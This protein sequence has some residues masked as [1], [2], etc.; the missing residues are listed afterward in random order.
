MID[1]LKDIAF[2]IHIEPLRTVEHATKVE[3][4]IKVLSDIYQSYNN[5]LEIE[6]LK[7]ENFKKVFETNKKVL[8]TIK[9]ELSLLVVDL[10]FSSFEAAL[11]P[12]VIELQSPI[13]KNEVLEWKKETFIEYKDL[14]IGGDYEDSNYL[15]KVAKRY[16]EEERTKIFK[17]LFLSFGDGKDYKV[18][19]KDKN[20]KVIKTLIQPEKTK[21]FYVIPKMI[22]EKSNVSEYSTFQVFAKVKKQGDKV[23][24]NQRNLKE[25]LYIEELEH[26][27]Y[28][29]KPDLIRFS[30]TIFV[31]NKVLDCVVE[32][33]DGNYIIKNEEFD[34]L[35][36]G[37][38]RKE[39]E[40][41]FCF[42]FYSIYKNYYDEKDINLSEEAIQLK[43]KLKKT[44][45]QVI[46]EA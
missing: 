36:W 44:I 10:N 16:N 1:K 3:T 39:A 35:V 21:D 33:E 15:L 29:Y 14:I 13:F 7:N 37:D 12:D 31:L 6:F 41:A 42:S 11:A 5:Y 26:D 23:K 27:T 4:V 24:L 30:E 32:F 43:R 46:N 20:H 9:E 19:V 40:E 17:P 34:L 8:D 28:P 22:N 38:T 45:K 18:N 25:I 2:R